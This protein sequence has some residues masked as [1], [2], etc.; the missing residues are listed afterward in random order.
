[1]CRRRADGG[2][3]QDHRPASGRHPRRPWPQ[4]WKSSATTSPTATP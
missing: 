4:S 1:V 3:G 2:A